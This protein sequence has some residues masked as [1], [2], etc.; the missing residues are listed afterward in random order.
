MNRKKYKKITFA[1][2]KKVLSYGGLLREFLGKILGHPDAW[3]SDLSSLHDFDFELS[4]KSVQHNPQ[5]IL[6]KIKRIYGVDVSDV[7]GLRIVDI[8]KR[9]QESYFEREKK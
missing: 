9:I 8:L 4:E 3:I 5:K 7:C 2:Q 1:S 6:R